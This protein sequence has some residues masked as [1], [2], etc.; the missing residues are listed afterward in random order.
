MAEKTT[1]IKK[2]DNTSVLKGSLVLKLILLSAVILIV[3]AFIFGFELSLAW[4]FW[5]FIKIFVGILLI[6][7]IFVM[8]KQAI[9]PTSFSPT[10]SFKDKLIRAAELSKPFNVK[11]LFLRG[12]NMRIYSRWGKITGLLFIPYLASVPII[13]D[14]KKVFINKTDEVGNIVKDENDDP[15]KILKMKTITHDDGDWFFVTRRGL[16]IIGKKDLVRANKK[17]V[18]GIGEQIWIEDV[19]LVPF[20][21]VHYPNK[22]WQSE[23]HR[24]IAQHQVET[25]IETHMAFLDIVAHVTQMSLGGDPTFQK[26]MLAQSEQ[27][28]S[29]NSGAFVQQ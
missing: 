24:C 11:E 1:S 6:V 10:E 25:I 23:M 8:I 4:I 22:Q 12:E 9:T 17:L 27:I 3:S 26:I 5:T 16:P 19:N 13:E 21:G 14:G 18:S 7:F 20:G 15:I 2:E 28:A 29:R